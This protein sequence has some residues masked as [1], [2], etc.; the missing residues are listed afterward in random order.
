VFGWARSSEPS[1]L[2]AGAVPTLQPQ[3]HH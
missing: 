1:R 3:A 2:P